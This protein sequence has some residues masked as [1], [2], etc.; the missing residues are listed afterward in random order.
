MQM[1][2]APSAA[3]Q[4]ADAGCRIIMGTD[5]GTPGYFHS[6]AVWREAEALVTLAGLTPMETI[7]ASTRLAAQALGVDAGVISKGRLADLILVRGNPL[8][9]MSALSRVEVV[10]KDGAVYD[11]ETLRGEQ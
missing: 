4:L 9:G 7:V 5:S 3:R 1:R 11:P 2:V 8:D 6:E 10:I